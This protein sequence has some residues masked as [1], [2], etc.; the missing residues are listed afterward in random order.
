[1]VEEVYHLQTAALLGM[2]DHCSSVDSGHSAHGLCSVG[3]RRRFEKLDASSEDFHE[4]SPAREVLLACRA[5][6]GS[7]SCV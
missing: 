5:F 7:L 6:V 4:V 1:M 2:A 3:I